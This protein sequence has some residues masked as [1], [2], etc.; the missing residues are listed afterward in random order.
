MGEVLST[1]LFDCT[2]HVFLAEWGAD[3][4]EAE[5]WVL[6]AIEFAGFEGF[7]G[8]FVTG[9]MG[10]DEGGLSFGVEFAIGVFVQ[11]VFGFKVV[12]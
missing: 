2:M 6:V 12:R 5:V 8:I 7:S 11:D 1:S 4:D 9:A 3:G 10:N